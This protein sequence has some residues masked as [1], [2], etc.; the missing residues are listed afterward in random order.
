MKYHCRNLTK[1]GLYNFGF[2]NKGINQLITHGYSN[3]KN[4]RTGRNNNQR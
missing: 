3:I 1:F 2:Q 4:Q